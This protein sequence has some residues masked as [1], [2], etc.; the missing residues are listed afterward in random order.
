MFVSIRGASMLYQGHR[1]T[2]EKQN[3]LKSLI[4]E[5]GRQ[6]LL[7]GTTWQGTLWVLGRTMTLWTRLRCRWEVEQ[8]VNGV[9]WPQDRE[10][11]SQA[12][13]TFPGMLVIPSRNAGGTVVTPG[14]VFGASVIISTS[15]RH[16]LSVTV[17]FP[18]LSEASEA[19]RAASHLLVMLERNCSSPPGYWI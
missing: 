19:S 6:A 10:R 8:I 7:I 14:T 11:T 13:L 15:A 12:C 16:Q 9:L 18:G 1:S 4:I 3:P 5:L 2:L 17:H